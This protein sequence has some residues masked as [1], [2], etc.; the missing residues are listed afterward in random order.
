MTLIGAADSFTIS[1]MPADDAT[2]DVLTDYDQ[3]AEMT[4]TGDIA[5]GQVHVHA[6]MALE[7]DRPVSGHLHQ[8]EI[9]THFARAYLVPEPTI[10]RKLQ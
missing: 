6:V 8:A 1:T 10:A 9:R 7:G 3:P 4:A 2:K 5:G